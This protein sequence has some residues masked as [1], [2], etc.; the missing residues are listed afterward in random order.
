M[1]A[2]TVCPQKNSKPALGSWCVVLNPIPLPTSPK[3]LATPAATRPRFGPQPH[4][5]PS[6]DCETSEIKVV[7]AGEG[8]EQGIG[9]L[10]DGTMVVIE[11]ARDHIGDQLIVKVTSTLQ[12]NAGRMIFTKYDGT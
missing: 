4:R 1:T 3:L 5:R 8:A 7:K 12:T 6:Q 2:Q 9:Y 10:N 11:G